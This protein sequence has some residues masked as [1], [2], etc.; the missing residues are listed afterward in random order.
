[1]GTWMFTLT[2]TFSENV[3][4]FLGGVPENK[5]AG[6]NIWSSLLSSPPQRNDSSRVVLVVMLMM[7]RQVLLVFDMLD[8]L[9]MFALA[10]FGR[11]HDG[12]G[13]SGD[14]E[15]Q[16]EFFHIKWIQLA[17]AVSQVIGFIDYTGQ[18][19]VTTF[20]VTIPA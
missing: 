10:G 17:P 11:R 6:P 13:E 7:F 16:N 9:R 3:R 19:R 1:M 2:R 4:F 5:K 14:G 18:S 15:K 8:D 20:L 12:K